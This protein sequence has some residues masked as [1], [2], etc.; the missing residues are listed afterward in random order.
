MHRF[1]AF[2]IDFL[3]PPT[4]EALALRAFS[5][6]ELV[7]K[8]PEAEPTSFP[9]ITSLFS[10]KD[11]LVSE[12]IHGIKNRKDPYFMEL[13]GWALHGKLEGELLV[14]IPLSKK[15]RKERGYNQCELLIEEILKLD[16]ENKFKKDFDYAT[17][18]NL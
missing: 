18:T 16:V 11:P 7:E 10:Y 1:F 17:K 6:A 4:K 8:L 9:F 12:L 13:G 5:P 15:R 2:L 14:P 3:F